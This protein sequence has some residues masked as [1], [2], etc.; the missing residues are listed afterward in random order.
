[1]YKRDKLLKEV[2][3]KRLSGDPG[4]YRAGLRH[5]DCHAVIWRY[6]ARE[7]FWAQS[8]MGIWRRLVMI[9]TASC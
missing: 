5:Q 3:E 6:A 8:S 9:C 7:I 1:M 2:A 4:I